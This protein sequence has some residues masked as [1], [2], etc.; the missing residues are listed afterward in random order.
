M[1]SE[2]LVV[3]DAANV[4]VVVVVVVVGVLVVIRFFIVLRL[5]HFKPIVI[6]LCIHNLTV[7]DFQ[8]KS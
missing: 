3:L 5:F 6:K 2:S 4:V 7:S 8:V 1:C